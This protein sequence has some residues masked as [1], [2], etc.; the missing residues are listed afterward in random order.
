MRPPQQACTVCNR[1]M[2]RMSASATGKCYHTAEHS[3]TIFSFIL[4]PHAGTVFVC[5]FAY[6]ICSEFPSVVSPS[7][8]GSHV[9]GLVG[10][11][12]STEE[13]QFLG[14][15]LFLS[16]LLIANHPFSPHCLFQVQISCRLELSLTAR[17]FVTQQGK[18]WPSAGS[19]GA[20]LVPELFLSHPKK[21][22]YFSSSH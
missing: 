7:H 19:W 9:C 14:H 18:D 8:Y 3:T 1:Q 10:S 22:T 17:T 4:S 5:M 13:V 16:H 6:S 2:L 20:P 11:S 12:C 21:P 15:N